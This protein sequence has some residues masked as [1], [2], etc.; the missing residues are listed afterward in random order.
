MKTVLLTF[1]ALV[2]APNIMADDKEKIIE[3]LSEKP[4]Q[5]EGKVVMTDAEWKE[6]LTP[7]QYRILREDGTERAY[8]QVY[9]EFKKH[10]AGTYHCAGCGA[11]LF[12]S[13]EKFDSKCGWPSF[14]DPSKAKN[15]KYNT[16]FHLGYARTE[17]SCLVCG[18]HLGHVFEGEGFDTPTDKR[19]CIN[20][21]ALM[22]V[23]AGEEF[24]TK[25]E[26]AEKAK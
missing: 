25:Q 7:E 4:A 6:K 3:V 21:T 2:A 18:G 16:D 9:D 10:G 23:P 26:K 12:T 1:L 19:Y 13:D 8:G 15:V 17:V 22:F 20:G 5:P 24:P 11:E 14:Y